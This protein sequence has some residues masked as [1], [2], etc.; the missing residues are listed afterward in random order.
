MWRGF[1]LYR[2]ED[3]MVLASYEGAA[4][5]VHGLVARARA[6]VAVTGDSPLERG[7]VIALSESDAPLFDTAEDYERA[8]RR[9]GAESNIS[10]G[11]DSQDEGSGKQPDIDKRLLYQ[12]APA[13]ASIDDIELDLPV[14]LREQFTH[15]L[16]TPTD[17][18]IESVFAKMIKASLD[19]NDIGWMTRRLMY[20]IADPK[21]M[22]IEES[23]PGIR[24]LFVRAWA[25]TAG[26]SRAQ[27][28]VVRAEFGLSESSDPESSDA[29]RPRGRGMVDPA[30]ARERLK[31]LDGL[32]IDADLQL[33][34]SSSP[35]T[36][37]LFWMRSMNWSLVVDL[38]PLRAPNADVLEG[39]PHYEWLPS[40]RYLPNRSDA[41]Q[42]EAKRL[43]HPGFAL[44]F[45][46]DPSRAAALMA[47]HSFWVRG[48]D[49]DA[50]VAVG[51]QFGLDPR[52]AEAVRKP[53]V[54]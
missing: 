10:V 2:G 18:L 46:D 47:A 23:T 39:S 25:Q 33:G 14:I 50:A 9:W 48:L 20:A 35:A 42:F 12:L 19:A 53:F 11:P 8:L 32:V 44:V 15:V 13:V 6:A 41:E 54:R 7:L 43:E 49:A 26:L 28:D 51:L 16:L 21:A 5:E 24:S 30:F 40:P 22:M 34:V 45:V 31:E 36:S 52:L 29:Y 4:S 3:A 27:I 1:R 17:A 37:F 38:N